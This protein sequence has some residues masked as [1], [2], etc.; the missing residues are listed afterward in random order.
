MSWLARSIATSLNIPDDSGP[1]D[2]PDA[3]VAAAS[4]PSE[5]IPPPP[6]LPH[7]LQ[8]A[9]ADGVKEDLTEL[10]KT[11]SRQFWGVANFLAPPPGEASPS[12][13]PSSA[14]G[15]STAAE[16]PP[17]IAGIRNDFSE[18]SGR[19]RTGISRI[20]THKAV[21]G[22]S[23]M[24]SNFF[25]SEDEEEELELLEAVNN[26]GKEDVRLNKEANEDEVRH[27]ADDDEVGHSWEERVRL[28]VGDDEARH[29]W[30][31]RAKHHVDDGVVWHQE[32]DEPEL[33][34]ERVRQE[35]EVEEWDAIGITDEVLAFATNIASHPETWLDFPL[36][37]DD[38][39]CDGPF[40]YFDMSDAQQE[41]A[42]AIEHLAPR[43]A[44]LR[45]ELCPVH[46]SEECF[47][48]TYFVLLHPRLSKHDAE[49]LSTPQAT[50][51]L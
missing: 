14:D 49:L 4:S 31:P 33:N 40:S 28:V 30:E 16:T 43:L 19:F 34:N 20:S 6:P 46:M 32:A 29:E 8:S 5:R 2:D 10:S 37:P 48:K 15:R 1:D 50:S 27:G 35:E 51:R 42:L 21:S 12:P 24:A 13:S 7:P 36:L 44:A 23:T 39:D 38:E 17:E 3:A 47:W 26:E 9:A 41:H 18:I 11:L 25:A 45:I 22:F